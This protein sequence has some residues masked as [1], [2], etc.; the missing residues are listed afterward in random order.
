[1][2]RLRDLVRHQRE[3]GL[4]LPPWLDRVVSAGIVTTDAQV[5]RRQ[6]IAN[7][8][9]LAGAFNAFSRVV[10]NLS[11]DAENHLLMQVVFSALVIVA[12]LIHRLHRFGDNAAAVALVL[13]FLGAVTA[14]SIFYGLQ[15]QAQAYFVLAGI[16]WLVVGLENWRLAIAGLLLVFLVMLISL[17]YLP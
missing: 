14:S 1:M 13:W 17:N 4:R 15:A 12:L 3:P 2:A 8:A 16:I 7:I 5:V 10:T 6:R 11:Y 9:A